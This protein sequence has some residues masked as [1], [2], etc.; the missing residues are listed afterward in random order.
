[1][2][3]N[4]DY[5]RPQT[6]LLRRM[7]EVFEGLGEKPFSHGQKHDGEGLWGSDLNRDRARRPPC[8]VHLRIPKRQP[9]FLTGAGPAFVKLLCLLALV[10]FLSCRGLG[11]DPSL[12]AP[13]FDGPIMVDA[14]EYPWSALGRVNAGGKGYCTGTLISD[15]HVLTKAN[16]LYNAIEGRWW[17]PSELHFIAGY[18]RDIYQI[19]SAVARYHLARGYGSGKTLA[20]LMND[21]AVLTLEQPIGREAGWIRL[22]WLNQSVRAHLEKGRAYVL[23]AGY[24]RGQ[25]HVI[26]V[27]LDCGIESLLR[28]RL[29]EQGACRTLLAGAGGLPELVFIDGEFRVLAPQQMSRTFVQSLLDGQALSTAHGLRASSSDDRLPRDTIHG[30]LQQ[31]GYTNDVN[32]H[33][34][35]PKKDAAIITRQTE[36]SRPFTD[37]TPQQNHVLVHLASFRTAN[38]ASREWERLKSRYPAQLTDL[39]LRIARVELG[40]Q[41]IFYRVLTDPIERGFSAR[42]LCDSLQTTGQYCSFVGSKGTAYN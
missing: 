32:G 37:E 39:S 28:L 9:A 10:G 15:R 33:A 11:V 40:S 22:Q 18:Q 7:E 1:M 2:F 41:G 3:R 17:H 27:K 16:C 36:R 5:H 42:R 35:S 26:T 6:Q 20:N 31:L 25:G 21:W 29:I 38:A 30:L 4:L 13:S 24:R 34:K 8:K 14:M 12:A 23:S 19:N